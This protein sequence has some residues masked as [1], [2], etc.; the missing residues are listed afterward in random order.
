MKWIDYLFY[1]TDLAPV[2]NLTRNYTLPKIPGKNAQ[3]IKI[4]DKIQQ[5]NTSMSHIINTLYTSDYLSKPVFDNRDEQL[6]TECMS[7]KI[8]ASIASSLEKVRDKLLAKKLKQTLEPNYKDEWFEQADEDIFVL[9]TEHQSPDIIPSSRSLRA[10]PRVREERQKELEKIMHYT[11]SSSEEKEKATLVDLLSSRLMAGDSNK[12]VGNHIIG[13]FHPRKLLT[14]GSQEVSPNHRQNHSHDSPIE[15][16]D[17]GEGGI[18]VDLVLPTLKITKSSSP[19][20][21]SVIPEKEEDSPHSST[22]NQE[23]PVEIKKRTTEPDD[24]DE[25]EEVFGEA[26]FENQQHDDGNGEDDM[27]VVHRSRIDK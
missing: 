6:L 25:H 23:K 4:G 13:S 1:D 17:C 21:G 26:D 5:I 14:H 18:K 8:P 2:P 24:K 19:R 11:K 15:I 27:E 9:E 16:D 10:D 20:K 3:R 12:R 22:N 7:L